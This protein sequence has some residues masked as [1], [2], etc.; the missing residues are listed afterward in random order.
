MSRLKNFF[1][2]F[3]D[4]MDQRAT[5]MSLRLQAETYRKGFQANIDG[6]VIRGRP[7]PCQIEDGKL[8]D[9]SAIS[10]DIQGL[11]FLRTDMSRS[12]FYGSTLSGLEFQSCSLAFA[13]F[14]KVNWPNATNNR[15]PVRMYKCNVTGMILSEDA[16]LSRLELHK[17]FGLDQVIIRDANGR[18]NPHAR[19]VLEE[20][21]KVK[22]VQDS[23]AKK[24]LTRIFD[25]TP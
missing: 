20:G 6:R 4:R 5:F 2:N 18:H 1:D 3:C 12:R 23:T 8:V 16:D 22:I 17:C 7:G 24:I 10:S 13:D 11:T 25:I 19:L 14:S 21:G 15:D 9:L